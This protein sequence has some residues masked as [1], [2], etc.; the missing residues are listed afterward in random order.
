MKANVK[1]RL[2]VGVIVIP[3]V[4]MIAIVVVTLLINHRFA[5]YQISETDD[6]IVRADIRARFLPTIDLVADNVTITEKQTLKTIAKANRFHINVSLWSLL[7]KQINVK[8]ITVSD[9]QLDYRLPTFEFVKPVED[10]ELA[11][12]ALPSG[13]S[14][15]VQQVLLQNFDIVLHYGDESLPLFIETFKLTH[16]QQ[17]LIELIAKVNLVPLSISGELQISDEEFRAKMHAMIKDTVI[18][19][20]ANYSEQAMGLSFHVESNNLADLLFFSKQDD[21]QVKATIDANFEFSDD[22]IQ[23]NIMQFKTDNSSLSGTIQLNKHGADIN[24]QIERLRLAD[25]RIDSDQKIV[26]QTLIAKIRKDKI[27]STACAKPWA[28]QWLSAWHLPY[29]CQRIT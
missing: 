29:T 15:H 13:W 11:E 10:N 20:Q 27:I 21:K 1:K 3:I 24:L 5:N 26:S 8:Q 16:Q 17:F 14:A 28:K 6:M 12:K 18:N 25:L 9:I 19:S 22:F 23:L 2:I 4:I 7:W